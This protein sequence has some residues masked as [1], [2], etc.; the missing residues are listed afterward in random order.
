VQAE[1]KARKLH[2]ELEERVIERTQQLETAHEELETFA[3]SISHDLRSPLR[4]IQ[5]FPQILL[6]DYAGQL[7]AEAQDYLKRV[8][9]AAQYMS[10]LIDGLLVFLRL[11]RRTLEKETVAP[12]KLVRRVLGRKQVELL[13]R[14]VV[15]TLDELPVCQAD[16]VLLEWVFDNLLSN[17]LKYTRQREQAQIQVGCKRE[18]DHDVY[19]VQDN[20]AGF[21]MQYASKLFGMFQRLHHA[22]EYEGT[23]I[24]LAIVQRIVQRHGGR[25]W[26]EAQEDH[27]ATFYF[28]L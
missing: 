10:E 21:D 19:F 22:E 17:A 20:G 24:D 6:E 26:A 8:S 25:V 13:Q 9:A 23:G 27:G 2:E 3:Y 4:A 18:N 14:Q 12:L 11:G 1:E 16:P 15:V 7:S 5:G 28:T